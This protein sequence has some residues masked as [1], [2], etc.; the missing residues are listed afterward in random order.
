MRLLRSWAEK[1]G[2]ISE[3]DA[4]KPSTWDDRVFLTIDIDWAIDPV[5]AFCLDL[6][7]EAGVAATIFV[8]HDTPLLSRMRANPKIE[9]GLHPNFNPLLDGEAVS[10]DAR[11][12]V[13]NLKR[14]VPEARAVR[15]HSMT[16]SSRLLDLF[17][18]LGMTHDCNHFVPSYSGIELRP[19]LHWNGLTR[20]PYFWEDD[21]DLISARGPQI[22]ECAAGRGLKV[23]DFHPIH[24]ALNSTS[25][26]HYEASRPFHRNW[27]DLCRVGSGERRG[28]RDTFLDFLHNREVS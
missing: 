17:L 2:K 3:I 8:T 22:L 10:G 13:E 28:V 7:D 15:S 4:A 6:I 16:Q 19:Y 21:V 1:F 12:V 24:V 23:F 11:A 27:I 20:V 5:I 9:L 14:I 25:I 26:E 18:K